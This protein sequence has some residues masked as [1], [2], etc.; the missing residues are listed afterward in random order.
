MRPYRLHY[1]EKN[2]KFYYI[3]DGKP[4]YIKVPDRISQKQL[5]K[6]NINF[7]A[8]DSFRVKRKRKKPKVSYSKKFIHNAMKSMPNSIGLPQFQFQPTH[9]VPTVGDKERE[10]ENM[11]LK[12]EDLLNKQKIMDLTKELKYKKEPKIEEKIV[13]VDDEPIIHGTKGVPSVKNAK[14]FIRRILRDRAEERVRGIL[15][16]YKDEGEPDLKSSRSH[17]VF[18]R[19]I[20]SDNLPQSESYPRKEQLPIPNKAKVVSLSRMKE[21]REERKKPEVEKAESS[22]ESESS[23]PSVKPMELSELQQAKAGIQGEINQLNKNPTKENNKKKRE[24]HKEIT[25]IEK[26]I[27]SMES[28]E[29]SGEGIDDG[30]FNDE[31]SK[32][33]KHEIKGHYVP[34]ISQDEI[35]TLP[36]YVKKGQKIFGAVINT[37]PSDSDGS[38]DDGY[39]KGHWVG[40]I[41]DARDSFGSCEYFDSLVQDPPSPE[42]INVL[43]YI[44]K[45]MSPDKMVKFKMNKIVRQKSNTSSCGIHVAKFI[46]DRFS[47]IPFSEASGY[48]HWKKS[49]SDSDKDKNDSI[50]GEKQID[51][52]KKTYKQYI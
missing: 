33:L 2:K 35:P 25:E 10:T 31:I 21:I 28:K 22:T 6:V 17:E 32:I 26:I 51:K 43:R 18:D 20:V 41:I 11:R 49:H 34:V 14:E 8:P 5:T 7:I 52:I 12:S 1:N 16:K 4:K 3:I 37:N 23:I 29:Q 46:E 13:E 44:C 15:K 9:F 30:L 27:R 38:G 47:G 36:Q 45:M 50:D 42:L 19:P 40:V 24:L 39:R 48:D